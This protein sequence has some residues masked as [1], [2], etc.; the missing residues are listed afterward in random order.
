VRL[1]QKCASSHQQYPRLLL[2][3]L[4]R[5]LHR[6]AA[7]L[8]APFLRRAETT[9][10]SACRSRTNQAEKVGTPERSAANLVPAV[11]A[12]TG[13][14]TPGP[15]RNEGEEPTGWTRLRAARALGARQRAAG[16]LGQL[17]FACVGGAGVHDEGQAHVNS[18]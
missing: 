1:K 11:A 15:W 10:P 14:R 16:P 2:P 9:A 6:G 18:K 17:R 8:P 3:V 4:P 13:A 12:V 5:P 7:A